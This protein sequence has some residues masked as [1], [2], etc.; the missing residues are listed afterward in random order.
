MQKR[1]AL[2]RVCS[3]RRIRP[4]LSAI[5]L[6]AGVYAGN[7]VPDGRVVRLPNRDLALS[8]T[9]VRTRL[10]GASRYQPAVAHSG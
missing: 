7:P 3:D 6:F 5:T 1:L 2:L 8:R 4:A 10:N 9:V